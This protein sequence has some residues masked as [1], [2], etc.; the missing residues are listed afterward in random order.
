MIIIMDSPFLPHPPTL[1]CHVCLCP[2]TAASGLSGGAI[3]AIVLGVI[4]GVAL[5]G[6]AVYYFVYRRK[7]NPTPFSNLGESP[8][9]LAQLLRSLVTPSSPQGHPGIA[10][11]GC[12]CLHV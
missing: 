10:F 1:P 7:N 9:D 4:M 5:I 8:S 6:G 3:A 2:F 12:T 11:C